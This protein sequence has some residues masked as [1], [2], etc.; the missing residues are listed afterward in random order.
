MPTENFILKVDGKFKV[1]GKLKVLNYSAPEPVV[2]Y[3]FRGEFTGIQ[4]SLNDAVV[5]LGRNFETNMNSRALYVFK[6]I[7]CAV[8][9]SPYAQAYA[10]CWELITNLPDHNPADP[11]NSLAD[12]EAGVKIDG[13]YI[14]GVP[15]GG[16]SWRILNP[17]SIINGRPA[18]IY[19]DET[20]FW[21]LAN[22]EYNNSTYGTL[23]TGAGNAPYPWQANWTNGFA[24][25]KS[26]VRS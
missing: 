22:W 25:E 18:Y 24:S 14:N 19:G 2:N 9:S 3:N 15:P 4:Y 8:G 6:N 11:L 16:Q 17:T 13:W 21:N 5:S 10:H 7:T 23:S 1:N 26:T 20:L 12:N